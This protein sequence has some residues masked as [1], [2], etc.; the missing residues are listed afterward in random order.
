MEKQRKLGFNIESD[1][2]KAVQTVL[3]KEPS[4]RSQRDRDIL[5]AF[6]DDYDSDIQRIVSKN[7]FD[8]DKD[9][10]ED[11]SQEIWTY[12]FAHVSKWKYKGHKFTAWLYTVGTG[13]ATNWWRSQG[14]VRLPHQ[15]RNEIETYTE[16]KKTLR[17]RSGENPTD[18]ELADELR[19]SMKKVREIALAKEQI[20][21]IWIDN[22]EN[23][24]ENFLPPQQDEFVDEPG[25]SEC[26]EQ[27]GEIHR[28]PFVLTYMKGYLQKEVASIMGIKPGTAR[29]R[30]QRAWDKFE[31]C[32]KRKGIIAGGV[33]P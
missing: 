22:N 21:L 11:L 5:Q 7:S 32:L 6:V 17:N 2:I 15:K 8:G 16:I 19:W 10:K 28:I 27:L 23:I 4:R 3:K 9:I 31:Q 18:Q 29:S 26:I 30:I 24:E 14:I 12:I 20:I 33:T 13:A 1:F 25:I